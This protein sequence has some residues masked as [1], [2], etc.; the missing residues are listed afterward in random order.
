MRRARIKA[1]V[2]ALY[3]R[4][5]RR[6]DYAGYQLAELLA[7]VLVPRFAFSEYGRTWLEDEEFWTYFRAAAGDNRHSADRKFLLRNMLALVDAV[8]GD[9][10]ECGTY[11]GASAL[12]LAGRLDGLHPLLHLFD[13][14]EGLP[15]PAA[16]DGEYW[17]V[18]DL[19]ATEALVRDRLSSF[20]DGV[21]FHRGWIP[22]RFEEV[23]DRTFSFVHIDVDLYEPTRVSLEF[24]Y[25]RMASG[26][27]IVFDDYGFVTCPGARVAIDEFAAGISEPAVEVPTGQAFLI[28][29]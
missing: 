16:V 18:G 7:G 14:F 13:S 5:A 20:G 4:F 22:D 28:K 2:R 1:G 24:F 8:P 10:A 26:G 29:R 23:A 25:P 3:R 15:E 27:V 21:V 17:S 19:R 11:Q 6:D 9:L 12:L